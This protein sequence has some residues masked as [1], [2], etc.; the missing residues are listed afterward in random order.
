MRPGERLLVA[1]TAAMFLYL[2]LFKNGTPI[3][4]FSPS[5][6]GLW[7]DE[8]YR[9][10]AGEVMYRDFFEFVPPGVV[11]LNAAVMT[12]F[13][14]RIAPF[15][16]LWLAV[17]TALGVLT[18]ALAGR[19]VGPVWRL[20]PP[21]LF[22]SIVYASDQIGDHKSLPPLFG[23]AALLLLVDRTRSTQRLVAAGGCAGLGLLCTT[24]LGLGVAL[25]LGCGLALDRT[26]GR[27]LLAFTLG[28]VAPVV[29]V[30]GWFSLQ[31]GL[32]TVLYDTIVFPVTR[33]RKAN[34]FVVFADFD[35]LRVA[36]RTL[37]RLAL[38]LGAILSALVILGGRRSGGPDMTKPGA[39]ERDGAMRLVALAGLGLALPLL[40]RAVYPL[41]LAAASALLLVPLAGA[42]EGVSRR[43]GIARH[44]GR[45][46]VV[47]LVFGCAWSSLGLV[48]R[49]QWERRY[50]LETHRAG[51]IVALDP[52]PEL[53][54]V[55]RNTRPGDEAFLF[56]SKGGLYFLS[57]LRN[58][59]SFSRLELGDLN[60]PAQVS[61]ALAEIERRRPAVGLL[62]EITDLPAFLGGFSLEPLYTGIRRSYKC[63]GRTPNGVL[64]LRLR[65][66][67]D[68][69]GA[70]AC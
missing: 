13:G 12:V 70:D 26:R 34:P 47:L 28:C 3:Y 33:Y 63:E 37:A 45:S 22:V 54:W 16:F 56:P 66:P 15:V 17:G 19:L 5:G 32:G 43:A 60:P 46:L 50:A 27:G 51:S 1:A 38:G 44:L 36:P 10:W 41:R 40:Q 53:A 14:P 25:G 64:L 8:A 24:D 35:E 9:V 58:P 2:A 48:Y 7:L 59:T 4:V 62:Q 31:A 30:L 42:L 67:A 21:A 69:A 23:L 61:Q 57:H 65:S 18:H 68:A 49:R 6:S 39:I 52:L 11:Y 29:L 55:E 20:L